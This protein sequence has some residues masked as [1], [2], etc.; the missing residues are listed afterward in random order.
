MRILFSKPLGLLT[1]AIALALVVPA[2]MMDGMFFDAT[3]YTS[4]GLNLANGMGTPWQL[5]YSVDHINSHPGFYENPPLGYWI[6]AMFFKLF[7]NSIFVERFYLLL[8]YIIS[9]VLISRIWNMVQP[10]YRSV[11]WL[12]ILLWSVMPLTFWAYT[13]NIMENTMA[14]FVF[15]AIILGW[16]SAV[17]SS[18]SYLWAALS[19]FSLFL[20]FMVKGVPGMY[21]LVTVAIYWLVYRDISFK[22]ML[23]LSLVMFAVGFGFIL[24]LFVFPESNQM[25]E[26]YFF[27]RTMERIN[28]SP[29]VANRLEIVREL[30]QQTLIPMVMV[31]SV[32]IINKTKSGQWLSFDK[33][34]FWFFLL[35]GLAGIL[36]LILTSVQRGF[37]IVP[38]IPL[39]VMALAVLVA[40]VVQNWLGNISPKAG[41]VIYV[42]SF[43]ILI[44]VVVASIALAGTPKRDGK[45]IVDVQ[46]VSEVV[47][48]H[49]TMVAPRS[50]SQHSSTK[51]YF[52]RNEFIQLDSRPISEGNEPMKW[53]LVEKGV[54]FPLDGY[55]KYPLELN[56]FELYR[57]SE[58]DE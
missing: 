37:Y 50:L 20:A 46:K 39:V 54:E 51:S 1:L 12:P 36:P 4:V 8:V 21:P 26:H 53:G 44:A 58:S 27:G 57:I 45:I 25:M 11:A 43:L 3:C 16:K 38:A 30:F 31:A 13:N 9:M 15:V 49:T 35:I 33:K 5:F 28:N 56:K 7:G 22:K 55:E 47:G 6:F 29:V 48:Q 52:M 23:G 14:L 2:L 41:K 32:T 24:M 34:A 18:K 19:G 17:S 42:L 40:D 10:K